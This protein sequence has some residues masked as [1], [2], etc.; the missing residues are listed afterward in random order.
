MET[1]K[2]ICARMI[3]SQMGTYDEDGLKITIQRIDPCGIIE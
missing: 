1:L 3:K 2:I